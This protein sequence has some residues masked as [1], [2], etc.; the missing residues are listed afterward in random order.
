MTRSAVEWWGAASSSRAAAERVE[1]ASH[2]MI[3]SAPARSPAR[4]DRATL[5]LGLENRSQILRA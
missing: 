4:R 2:S 5:R 3:S 1:V